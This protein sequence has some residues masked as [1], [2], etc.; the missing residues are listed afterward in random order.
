V[1]AAAP[2]CSTEPAEQGDGGRSLPKKCGGGEAARATMHD[3]CRGILLTAR[4]VAAGGELLQHS[5]RRGKVR[6]CLKGRNGGSGWTS[7]SNSS[8]DG[9]PVMVMD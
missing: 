3:S 7:P 4:A 5:Q 9:I 2:R 8:G 6:R 1:A